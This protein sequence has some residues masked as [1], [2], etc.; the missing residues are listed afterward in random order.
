[1]RGLENSLPPDLQFNVTLQ[2][3]RE[4][5]VDYLTDQSRGDVLDGAVEFERDAAMLWGLSA[6]IGDH[7]RSPNEPTEAVQAAVYRAACF[8]L[9]V[10]QEIKSGPIDSISLEYFA[11]TIT[12]DMMRQ[13]TQAYLAHRQYIDSLLGTF[14]PEIDPSYEYPHH[15]ETAAGLM[16]MLC[17]QRLGA[18][19]VRQQF[20]ATTPDEIIGSD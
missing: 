17:E 4:P 13:D 2:D 8:A 1:M 16:F 3:V 6:M 14:M 12:G 10:V 9:Q 19:Y 20:D 5:L 18:Q 15:V 7:L 11:D